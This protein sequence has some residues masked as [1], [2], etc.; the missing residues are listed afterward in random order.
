MLWQDIKEADVRMRRARRKLLENRIPKLDHNKRP[1]PGQYVQGAFWGVLAMS[2]TLVA[3]D[4]PRVCDTM[5][6]DG[7]NLY[8]HPP[9]VMTLTETQCAAVIAHE[10]QHCGLRHFARQDGR[11]HDPWNVATDHAINLDLIAAGFDLPDDV[12]ADVRFA[13]MSAE[14]IYPIVVKENDK[15]RKQGKPDPHQACPWG[16]VMDNPSNAD[17]TPMDKAQVQAL[18]DEWSERATQAA[19]AARK[20]GK[21]AGGHV[22]SELVKLSSDLQVKAVRDWR[23]ELRQFIDDL[24]HRETSWA[25]LDRRGMAYGAAYPADIPSVPSVI[26]WHVDISSSMDERANRQALVEAQAALD[27]G[28]CDAIELVYVNTVVVGVERYEAGDV[29]DFKAA[30]K[31]GTNFKSA[32]ARAAT[33]DDYAAIVFVTDGECGGAWGDEP[34]MP[35]L[36]ALTTAAPKARSMSIPFGQRLCLYE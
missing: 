15:A 19:G 32:M 27:D 25:R 31:G 9:Y 7:V 33:C 26:G 36:W 11:E 2:L 4:D 6:V 17:G 18:A 20:A 30:T 34:S 12:L 13:D 16:K 3:I 35:V 1:L 22:P 24:G 21:M 8:Y 28:A 5:A 29:I 23:R 10:A 14:Q